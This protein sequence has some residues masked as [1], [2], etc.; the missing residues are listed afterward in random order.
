MCKQ[1]LLGNLLV[2]N[3]FAHTQWPPGSDASL[4]LC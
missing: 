3:T 1:V 4:V 2:E